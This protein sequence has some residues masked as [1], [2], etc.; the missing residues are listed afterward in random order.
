MAVL[1][2]LGNECQIEKH[3]Q[4]C[5]TTHRYL[6]YYAVLQLMRYKLAYTTDSP[7]NYMQQDAIM[8]GQSSHE[9]LL[10]EIKNR[11]ANP[12]E[13]MRF[14]QD[15]EDLKAKRVEADYSPRVFTD[16]ESMECKQQA[17]RLISKLNNFI[18]TS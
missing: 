5:P 11:I 16:M 3:A 6:P 12:K 1:I 18:K 10:I 9:A 4:R 13:K 7:L 15:F 17:N 14:G 2:T 8:K